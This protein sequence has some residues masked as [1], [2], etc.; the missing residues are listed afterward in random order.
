[1]S[2]YFL[3]HSCKTKEEQ[4]SV[5]VL[6]GVSEQITIAEVF[7]EFEYISLETSEESV[8][9]DINRLIVYEDKFF[10]LD[11]SK[12]KKVYVFHKDGTFSHTIGQVG[13]GPEEYANIEDFTID[14]EQRQ[15]VILAYPS[16]VHVYDMDGKFIHK[17]KLTPSLL[18][19]IHS[20][21]DGFVCSTNHQTWTT[22]EDAL[23]IY[24]FDKEFNLKNKLLDVLPVQAAMPPF[25]SNTLQ[26]NGS[27]IL[28]FDNFTST[29]Y[30]NITNGAVPNS[31]HFVFDKE[32]PP[33]VYADP[34]KFFSNQN[35]YCFF[36]EAFFV[37]N[38]LWSAFIDKGKQYLFIRDFNTGK[39]LLSHLQNL[40]PKLLFYHNNHFY[41]SM[42]SFWILEGHNMFSAQIVTK[43]PIE[44][45]SNPVILKF[46]PKNLKPK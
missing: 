19:N 32:I 29:A 31:V 35:D 24:D 2:I 38:V 36:L 37:N 18:W 40:C 45:D 11:N 30:F 15:A 3:I 25:I 16:T 22:G 9:G 26:K 6:S 46:K 4:N 33:E 44:P 1:M 39:Q 5:I 42:N 21:T 17:K 43:Y 12:M 13:G 34:Q 10:I 23:L 14:E 28:Y 20:Y 8:F 7:D 41:S 27:E